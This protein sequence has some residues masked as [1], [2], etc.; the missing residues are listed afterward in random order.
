MVGF[1]VFSTWSLIEY[2]EGNESK[3]S[4]WWHMRLDLILANT[5]VGI[6]FYQM[7]YEGLNIGNLI[8]FF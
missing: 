3:D 6:C 2:L 7:C 8:P 1:G 4:F 5:N